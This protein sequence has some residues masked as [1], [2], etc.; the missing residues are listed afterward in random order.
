M[1]FSRLLLGLFIS[2]LVSSCGGGGDVSPG[3]TGDPNAPIYVSAV[4]FSSGANVASAG[5]P[6]QFSGGIC[7]G[8]YGGLF[9]MWSYGDES[10]NGTSNSHTYA[11]S[12]SYLLRVTCTDASNNDKKYGITTFSVTVAP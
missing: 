3:P 6:V 11:R 8:G 9:A 1:T 12:G 2:T 10:P 4:R 5:Q 7:S